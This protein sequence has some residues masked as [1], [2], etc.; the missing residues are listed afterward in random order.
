[1]SEAAPAPLGHNKGPVTAPSNEDLLADLQARFPEVDQEMGQ[2]EKDLA[3]YP[4]KLTLKDEDIAKAMQD[5]LAK[6]K[7]LKSNMKGYKKDEKAPWSGLVNVVMN[8]FTTREEK[9]DKM[10]ADAGAVHEDFLQQKKDEATRLA[11]EE[12]E[13]Q[14]QAAEAARLEAEAAQR[15]AEEARQREEEA[16]RAEEEARQRQ[17]AE[18]ARARAAREEADRLEAEER[19]LADER[20]ARERAEKETNADNLKKIRGH[21]KEADKLNTAIVAAGEE[22]NDAEVQQLDALIKAGGIVSLLITPVGNSHLLDDTQAA[23]VEE[24]KA[25]IVELRKAIGDRLDAK[26]RRKRER[27]RKE[28]EE[29]EKAEAER[30]RLAREA[31]EERSRVAKEAREKAEKEADEA[32]ASANTAKGEARE[33]RG[34][35]RAAFSD[36]KGATKDAAK[37]GQ[38]ADR[39]DNRADRVERKLENSTDADLSR[40]RGDLGSVGG[41]RR[42]W[43]HH[44]VDEGK[45]RAVS[46]PLGPHFTADALENALFH[47][48]RAHQSAFTGERVEGET[49]GVPGALFTYES[50]AAIKG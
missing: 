38:V 35:Q 43:K 39:A 22:P 24:H 44:V 47:V 16:K 48:M 8:F 11:E 23:E 12:A 14:R 31:D 32:K 25:R 41:L 40:T 30:R 36:Q 13:R 5:L 28:E 26:E 45:L 42:T 34:E 1:M 49:I 15:R 37:A 21:M 17:A 2:M 46:G 20:K 4:K 7:K 19:R 29:R 27:A 9:L 3:T 18:E 50:D 6:G 10:L 33:A